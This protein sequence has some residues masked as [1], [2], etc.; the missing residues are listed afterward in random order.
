M[1]KLYFINEYNKKYINFFMESKKKDDLS[2]SYMQGL[3]FYYK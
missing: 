1:N 3:T 2:D